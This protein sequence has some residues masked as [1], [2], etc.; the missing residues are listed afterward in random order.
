M[1]GSGDGGG[2]LRRIYDI[3]GRRRRSRRSNSGLY[4]DL[5]LVLFDLGE[6]VG[7][8][9]GVLVLK[10]GQRSVEEPYKSR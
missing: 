2:R 8:N 6:G 10:R 3:Q 7:G 9:N 5:Y 4:G 1:G